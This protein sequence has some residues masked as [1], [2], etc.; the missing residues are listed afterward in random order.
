M[1]SLARLRRGGVT[2][3]KQH[4]V[5]GMLRRA[6]TSAEDYNFVDRRRPQTDF[7]FGL[8]EERRAIQ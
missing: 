4:V 5:V 2:Y 7:A 1:L 6:S 8:R 3:N